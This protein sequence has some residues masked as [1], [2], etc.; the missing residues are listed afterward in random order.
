MLE[1]GAF[2]TVMFS[3]AITKTE[4]ILH[5]HPILMLCNMPGTVGSFHSFIIL[6]FSKSLAK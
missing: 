2:P 5:S 3:L 6:L 4:L 1:G